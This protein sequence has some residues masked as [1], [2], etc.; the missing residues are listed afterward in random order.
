MAINAHETW[1]PENLLVHRQYIMGCATLEPHEEV[2]QR[3][4]SLLGRI[5]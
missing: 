2:Q 1:P 4:Q 5:S 3:L